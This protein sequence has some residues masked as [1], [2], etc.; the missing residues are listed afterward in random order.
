MKHII[1]L[2]LSVALIGCAQT[3]SVDDTTSDQDGENVFAAEDERQALQVDS[4]PG[5]SIIP[6][7][8]GSPLEPDYVGRWDGADGAFLVVTDPPQRG[9]VL[10][11]HRADD[12]LRYAGSVT[13]EGL[14]FMRG[15]VAEAAILLPEANSGRGIC[16]SVSDS[17]VYCRR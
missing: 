9:L 4:E 6:G 16:L 2:M 11:F 15:D 10:E 1:T 13:A 3:N 12:E 8:S 7:S 17:E 5:S 14:R